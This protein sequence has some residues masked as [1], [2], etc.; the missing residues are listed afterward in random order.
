[1]LKCT[2]GWGEKEGIILAS[3]T[4]LLAE[5]MSIEC[6]SI[7]R[8]NILQYAETQA[9]GGDLTCREKSN[10]RWWETSLTGTE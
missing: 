1:M 2:E 5:A 9:E 4:S 10:T 7:V 3:A 6:T 8:F